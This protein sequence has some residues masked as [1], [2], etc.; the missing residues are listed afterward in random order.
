LRVENNKFLTPTGFL[1]NLSIGQAGGQLYI[2]GNSF[3]NTTQAINIFKQTDDGFEYTNILIADNQLFA[4][5][6]TPQLISIQGQ[7]NSPVKNVTITGNQVFQDGGS[8]TVSGGIV[9]G[10][11]VSGFLIASNYVQSTVGT[12]NGIYIGA[13]A[14]NG[15]VTGNY[16][17][18]WGTPVL[19]NSGTTTV[20][21][22]FTP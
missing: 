11:Y 1:A 18:G 8:I 19:N 2:I 4:Y 21:N 9:I 5:G 6:A 20:A 7:A 17:A 12:A 10:N 16:I 14:S 13:Q 15:F 3:D 22:N